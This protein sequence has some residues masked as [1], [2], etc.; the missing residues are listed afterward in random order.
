MSE[1]SSPQAGGEVAL[2]EGSGVAQLRAHI[3]ELAK[4][5]CSC[6]EEE[7]AVKTRKQLLQKVV[8]TVTSRDASEDQ[9]REA[10]QG[11]LVATCTAARSA[12]REC[13]SLTKQA[14]GAAR[15]RARL[16]EELMKRSQQVDRLE[17]LCK[18]L[19][20]RNKEVAEAARATQ[21][22]EAR[23]REELEERLR[24]GIDG[25]SR[26][27]EGMS[28]ERRKALEQVG[29]AEADREEM[30]GH[31]AKLLEQMERTQEVAK[32]Q[33]AAHGKER[34]LLQLK[35]EHA[36]EV[37]R[38]QEQ[39]SEQLE[40]RMGE[41]LAGF[42]KMKA[43]V[44]GRLADLEQT[45]KHYEEVLGDVKGRLDDA[46]KKLRAKEEAELAMLRREKELMETSAKHSQ[47]LVQALSRNE[48]QLQEMK[49]VIAQRDRLEALCR[50]LRGQTPGGE[51]GAA[52]E[53]DAPAAAGEG[54]HLAEAV[55]AQ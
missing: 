27:V 19:Q 38:Q 28:E 31:L 51:A 47:M 17:G 54:S 22:L 48:E 34:E 11:A 35:L 24:A 2:P 39:R 4:A 36:T 14:G 53:G 12:E 50:A 21:E 9:K 1:P 16:V 43:L 23:R 26:Q 45:N 42:E 3:L 46:T 52:K 20:R 29:R 40:A 32:K 49:R 33:E 8:A 13:K 18:E 30:R 55:P 25:I 37:A 44:N 10:L 6:K 5:R 15:E 7:E 41:S